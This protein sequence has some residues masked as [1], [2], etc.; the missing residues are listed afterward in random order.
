MAILNAEREGLGK[1]P[2]TI[3]SLLTSAAYLHSE[4]M[5][6]LNYFSH[7]SSDGRTFDQRI[8]AA[9]Y[10]N[11]SALAENIAY[12]YGE[13]DAARV[14][15]MWK[16]SSGHYA[17]MMGDY[18][19][20]GLGVYSKNGYTYYTLDLGK[21]N[22]V[23]IPEFPLSMFPLAFLPVALFFAL[24]ARKRATKSKSV[25]SDS[26]MCFVHFR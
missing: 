13:P 12:A 25:L 7:T 8:I 21:G 19:E 2:L 22:A 3:N 18:N 6:E 24:T 26:K 9:G 5:A 23:Q 1:K 10:T 11:Y 20:V 16:N 14:Y 15:T 4:D 17:N